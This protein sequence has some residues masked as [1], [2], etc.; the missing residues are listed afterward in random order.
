MVEKGMGGELVGDAFWSKT[1]VCCRDEATLQSSRN[2]V[3]H[4]FTERLS[5]VKLRPPLATPFVD[6]FP[7]NRQQR[8]LVLLCWS[9]LPVVN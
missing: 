1:R 2:D 4:F 8:A 5:L 7:L 9:I 6:K 3:T